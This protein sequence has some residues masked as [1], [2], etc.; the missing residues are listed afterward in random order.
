M[1]TPPPD[2][3]RGKIEGRVLARARAAEAD[4]RVNIA[5]AIRLQ[6]D[7]G[8]QEAVLLQSRR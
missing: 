3:E 6:V 2:P 5:E 1:D 7:R 8:D 4:S